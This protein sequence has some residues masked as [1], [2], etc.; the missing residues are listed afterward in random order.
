V[1]SRK[2]APAP[3]EPETALARAGD[4]TSGAATESAAPIIE[5]PATFA[6]DEAMVTIE[7]RVQDESMVVDLRVNDRPVGL[8]SDGAFRFERGVPEGSS[9]FEIVALDE[10]GN[11]AVTEIE[12][13]RQTLSLNFGSYHA[14][15][16]G[17][18][19]Y[20]GMPTLRTA[21]ADAE[22]I[23]ETLGTRYGFTVD[24]LLNAT[25]HDIIGAMS[26]LRAS[27]T[28]EDNLLIY[29]AG[30]GVIDPV[31]ERGYWLP[32]DADENNPANWVSNDDITNMLKAFPARHVLVVADSC[33]SGALTRQV[34]ARL[35]TWQD[36]KAWLERLLEKRSR[37]VLSSGGLEPVADSGGSGHSVFAS[38]L[39]SVL[40]E[41]TEIVEAQ[42]LF[43]PVRQR[44][45]LNAN[46]T[47][48]YSD[49][50]LAGHE[51]GD[52]VF[53]PQ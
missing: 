9:K 53:V 21:V 22:A 19:D 31:T 10:W 18:N 30:H 26:A 4:G 42:G 46:Q 2:A 25:R 39:L 27:L 51:G 15:V 16:I 33:Y 49:V 29:Y 13:T 37:T 34:A 48:Q 1:I 23:A 50:R 32:V 44:V 52:F 41:N 47:P 5:V 24:L 20:S 45:V 11:R 28:F 17:N 6:T 8:G 35:E 12:V 43:D 14:L 3:S 38:A 7:G 40:R 36:R